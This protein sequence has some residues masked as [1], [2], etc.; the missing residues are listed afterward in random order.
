MLFPQLNEA[1]RSRL[2]TETFRGYDHRD[3]ILP[4]QWY[5][6]TNIS[7]AQY[8]LFAQRARRG[9]VRNM[10][11][12][13][14]MLA[15][16]ALMWIDGDTLYYNEL[17]VQGIR[18]STD[19]DMQPKML[20]SMG[21]YAVI[22]PDKVYV[23]TVDLTD[24]GSLDAKYTADASTGSFDVTLTMCNAVGEIYEN[25]VVSDSAPEDPENGLHWV[26]TSGDVHILKVWSAATAAWGEIAT[27]Y[28]RIDAHGLGAEGVFEAGDGIEISGLEYDGADE[29]VR[30]QIGALNAANVIVAMGEGYIVVTGILDRVHTQNGGLVIKRECPDMD[31][32]CESNNRIWGCKYG[33]DGAKT[34][35]EIYACKL[36]DPK[37]WRC[38]AGAS[39]DSYAVSLGT[40]GKFT[41]AVTYLGYPLF[42]KEN[43]IHKIYGSIPESFGVQTTVCRGVQDGAWRSLAVVNEVLYYQSRT[44][45]CAYDG[46][47]PVG[48]SAELGEM[49][50]TK[51]AAGAD[52]AV[53]YISMQDADGVW[54]MFTY[55]TIKKLWHREDTTRALCFANVRGDLLYINADTRQLISASGRSGV[56]EG[57]VRWSASSGIMGYENPY[58]QYLSRYS[59]RARLDVGARL[60]MYIE[61]DSEGSWIEQ[62]TWTGGD[63]VRTINIPVVPRRCDHLRLRLSGVGDVKIYSIARYFEGGSDVWR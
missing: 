54:S 59:I 19:A 27:V 17:P 53:Y 9:V 13:L 29:S 2:V 38:Y 51:G 60:T 23:N 56:K 63:I 22:F 24:C 58:S 49:R 12:P 48:V 4:G 47:L 7:A 18:L 15:K 50:Y 32:V 46:S 52:G 6:E 21:A 44:D 14:G 16:D 5:D 43:A 61:Y 34:V 8:P 11:E 41:G 20:V 40:D 45:I 30:A 33:F 36:G 3:K 35:N 37:N 31:Y 42:F 55:D 39:T 10:A 26:D 28:V 1:S 57:A 62:G 25:T